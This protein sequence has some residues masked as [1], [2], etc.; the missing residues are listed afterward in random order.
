MPDSET[1]A[2]LG[3]AHPR[4]A[5]LLDAS[6]SAVAAVPASTVRVTPGDPFAPDGIVLQGIEHTYRAQNGAHVQAL[7]P[8]DVSVAAGSFVALLGP[9]GCGKSTLL[10]I[11]SGLL[12]P[13]HGQVWLAGESPLAARR[14]RSIGWLAQDDGLLP[15]L[16]VADNVG[17]PLRLAGARDRKAEREML[18]RVGLA[19][20]ASRYPHELSGGMRQRAALA[21]ALIARP[22]FVLLDEPFAHLDELTRERL[23]DLLLE[24]RSDLSPID[25][26]PTAPAAPGPDAERA[27]RVDA[28][29]SDRRANDARAVASL[30][31][32]PTA[33]SSKAAN[34]LPEPDR[35]S[36]AQS[37]AVSRFGLGGPTVETLDAPSAMSDSPARIGRLAPTTVLVTHSV[38]EAVRLADRVLLFSSRPGRVLLDVDVAT[39]LD[40]AE[41]H[42]AAPAFA[43]LV[44]ELKDVLFAAPSFASSIVGSSSVASGADDC[45]APQA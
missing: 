15:W 41:R 31:A 35:H 1:T 26:R 24:L 14:R 22:P 5:T 27:A 42:E 38:A 7:A 23:G 32:S 12:S 18:E 4:A 3:T 36:P 20:T 45:A 21:R 37:V 19:G 39:R 33:T 8:T 40:H 43:A 6:T 34:V 29:G 17:L 2:A 9:S 13:T 16:S 30:R 44:R 11:L 25:R 28:S 10:R